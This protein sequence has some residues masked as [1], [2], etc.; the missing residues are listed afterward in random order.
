MALRTSSIAPSQATPAA[1]A[2][3]RGRVDLAVSVAAA[4]LAAADLDGL[5]TVFADVATWE[6]EQRAYQARCRLAELILAYRPDDVAAWVRTF[7]AGVSHLLDALEREP[8]EPVLLNHLGVLLYE[9][10]EAGA[11]AD[12]FRAAAR[13]DP[14]LPHAAANL[15]AARERARSGALLPG[16]GATRTRPLAERARRLAGRARPAKKLSISL[17]MIVK[18][19]EEMLPGCLEPLQGVVDEMIVVDTGSSDRTV[20]IAE[21]FGAKVVSFPWNGSFSDA[22]NASIE[23]A[24]GDWLIYLDA[25]EHMEAQDARHLRALLGRTWREGFYLVETNYTGGSDAGSAVT[26]MALRVWRNRPQY[27]FSGRIHEQKTHT[28]PTYLPE[29]FET[30]RI[31]VR[32]YGYLNQRLVSKDKSRRNIQLLEQEA[33]ESRTPFTDY[34]LG[35]EY[36]VLADHAAARTHLDRSWE[37]LREQGLESVGYAPLLVS[38][39]ARA[40]R[41]VGDFEAAIAAVEEGLARFP[42]HTDL[43]LEAAL[44]AR[45]RGDLRKAG[46]LAGRCL[47]M[48]DAPAEYASTTGAGTFLAMTLLAEVHAA[49]G[50]R[51]GQETILRRSLAEH[52]D[53]IAPVLPLVELLIAR[54]VDSAEI[55]ALVPAKVPARVLAGTAYVEGGRSAD[56]ERWFRSA[57]E[58]QPSN[59]AARMGL[60]ESLLAQRR[61]AD[62]AEVAAGEPADSP[63]AARAAEAVV[64]ASALLGRPDDMDAAVERTAASLVDADAD[65]FRAWATAIRGG[66]PPAVLGTA[67]GPTAVRMLEALL[68]VTETDAFTILLGVFGRVQLPERQRRELL[69]TMYLRRGFLESAADEWIAVATTQPDASAMLGL[70]QVALARGYDQ[71]AVDFAA[72]AVRLEPQFE[73]ARVAYN[74][75]V[76]KFSQVA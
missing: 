34:N 69:A 71:D 38:R 49:Q 5:A 51:A 4:R 74:A 12:V 47:E 46:E 42:D 14:D 66:Q 3:W 43:V 2:D 22:R 23:A 20:E 75:I 45:S 52:P 32:H 18:D 19:E 35:S 1:P 59:S 16:V 40:R 48:G 27:R 44:A 70:A 58:A 65:L 76:K 29:R 39:V 15:D 73:G 50:D 8:R 7:I 21:S 56:A 64:F 24:S 68:R 10:C 36:L 63:L 17:C 67:A 60:S 54:G 57:L 72:E 33:Q 53:Y 13:L 9:L 26:H 28:M 55:D 25:D 61:Y 30:T 37:A 6:D 62:A 31:R 41:E 11:A